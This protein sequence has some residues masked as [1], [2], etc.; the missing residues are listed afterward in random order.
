MHIR[1]RILKQSF[2]ESWL[3]NQEV[4][5]DLVLYNRYTTIDIRMWFRIIERHVKKQQINKTTLV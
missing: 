2:V 3:Y 4:R 1:V 5:R